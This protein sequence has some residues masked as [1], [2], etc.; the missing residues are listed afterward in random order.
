MKIK[1]IIGVLFGGGLIAALLLF[2]N[3]RTSTLINYEN[4]DYILQNRIFLNPFPQNEIKENYSADFNN[5]GI[6]EKTE[7]KNNIASVFS[8]GK[9]IF[10]TDP[11][12]KVE[13]IIIG[14]FN[15]DG[16]TD[17]GLYLWKKGSYGTSR[18]FWVK[19]NDESYR[20]HLFLYDWDERRNK[21]MPLW[22][23][24]NLPYINT[25]TILEDI[26][27]DGKNE[28]IVLEKPYDYLSGQYAKNVAVWRWNEWGFENIW[29]SEDGKFDDLVISK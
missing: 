20:Q 24:S 25:K 22:H 18:P 13:E 2:F 15:N 26:D 9:K 17:L 21:I 7:L 8:N 19:E 12:W 10:E 4:N 23:S 1:T 27:N 5:D 14:D 16:N 29:R 11:T 6:N 3:L 28:L